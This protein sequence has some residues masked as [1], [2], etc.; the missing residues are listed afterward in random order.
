MEEKWIGNGR[1]ELNSNKC[2]VVN[3]RSLSH[4]FGW[5]FGRYR[6]QAHFMTC[7]FAFFAF[8]DIVN[9]KVYILRVMTDQKREALN[10]LYKQLDDNKINYSH[11]FLRCVAQSQ[12]VLQVVLQSS[13]E[14]TLNQML[15]GARNA[16][17]NALQSN[18]VRNNN[19]RAVMQWSIAHINTM[20]WTA[21]VPF[22]G[23]ITALYTAIWQPT[24]ERARFCNEAG[25]NQKFH[26]YWIVNWAQFTALQN[27]PVLVERFLRL[28]EAT[29]CSPA[30]IASFREI[31]LP[32]T[33]INQANSPQTRLAVIAAMRQDP[34]FE[35]TITN[36][37]FRNT[38]QRALLLSYLDWLR[39][40]VTN[41]EHSRYREWLYDL[42]YL[43]FLQRTGRMQ[44]QNW[45]LNKADFF[46]S[47][48][49]QR[50]IDEI[51]RPD[52][53]RFTR[54]TNLRNRNAGVYQ[55]GGRLTGNG[56]E[57]GI[58]FSPTPDSIEVKQNPRASFDVNTNANNTLK[59]IDVRDDTNTS[60]WTFRS[61]EKVPL[62][63]LSRADRVV[64]TVWVQPQVSMKSLLNNATVAFE[65]PEEDVT[66]EMNRD[67]LNNLLASVVPANA[68]IF[69]PQPRDNVP[70]NQVIESVP[71]D[72][73]WINSDTIARCTT[74]EMSIDGWRSRVPAWSDLTI[75]AWWVQMIVRTRSSNTANTP[76]VCEVEIWWVR[77]G[78]SVTTEALT[79]EYPV[80]APQQ[81]TNVAV[82][83]VIESDPF[84]ITG[85]TRP[86]TAICTWGEMSID[87]WLS[88]T[89]AWTNL[90]VPVWVQMLLR[91]TSSAA[92]NTRS[93]C[94]VDIWWVTKSFFVTTENTPSVSPI[95]FSEPVWSR[96]DGNI[97]TKAV[98]RWTWP[99]SLSGWT[100]EVINA[101]GTVVLTESNLQ[102]NTTG[103]WNREID[104]LWLP[105]GTYMVRVAL[106]TQTQDKS[107]HYTVPTPVTPTLEKPTDFTFWDKIDQPCGQSIDSDSV[108]IWWLTWPVPVVINPPWSLIVINGVEY[109]TAWAI[110]DV[111][112]G[113]NV[114]LRVQSSPNH[115]TYT[116]M[117]VLIGSLPK[118]FRVRTI[119]APPTIERP[120]INKPWSFVYWWAPVDIEWV[121]EKGHLVV[122]RD[123][124]TIL[125][126]VRCSATW[127]WKLPVGNLTEWTHTLTV[128]GCD[129]SWAEVAWLD[130]TLDIIVGYMRMEWL[131]WTR[132]DI[133][134]RMH[135][136]PN[137]RYTARR[138]K[139]DD[140][141]RNTIHGLL[142]AAWQDNITFAGLALGHGKYEVECYQSDENEAKK[143]LFTIDPEPVTITPLVPN[144]RR[145]RL[146]WTA[147]A[148][149]EVIIKMKIWGGQEK[150]YK[151]QASDTWNRSVQLDDLTSGLCTIDVTC[152]WNTLHEELDLDIPN[153]R[154]I[155]NNSN[156]IVKEW[157]ETF[158]VSGY[159]PRE[160]LDCDRVIIADKDWNT[161][162][163]LDLWNRTRWGAFRDAGR[164]I[165][166][167]WRTR[168]R[169]NSFETDLNVN[170][171]WLELWKNT[172]IQIIPV[173]RDGTE[174]TQESLTT[175][176]EYR[177]DIHQKHVTALEPAGVIKEANVK[178]AWKAPKGVKRVRV[179]KE[180]IG[181][182]HGRLRW[183]SE[184]EFV[185]VD[186]NGN[187][188]TTKTITKDGEQHWRVAAVDDDW[189][190]G[191][192]S[193][194][195]FV[196]K[197]PENEGKLPWW[198]KALPWNWFGKGKKWA[199]KEWEEKEGGKWGKES[200]SEWGKEWGENGSWSKKTW[201]FWGLFGG[202]RNKESMWSRISRG[203]NGDTRIH[204]HLNDNYDPLKSWK[205]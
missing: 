39:D 21:T 16:L 31:L 9:G 196:M 135:G 89:P 51:I 60:I 133:T 144:Q 22:D 53:N 18:V 55:N 129:A 11:N 28:C 130:S 168:R 83:T 13:D 112:N 155:L 190:I 98:F 132:N 58:E 140:T 114:V 29:W 174:Y 137:K 15:A 177:H 204:K 113:D 62:A 78:F 126:T 100:I 37:T 105:S 19:H 200:W 166:E 33:R 71:F 184:K 194:I 151:V 118:T 180:G 157:Q 79:P 124:A 201:W 149:E 52:F 95:V 161:I 176:V 93:A 205:K 154:P 92:Y 77:R 26:A 165:L 107:I 63:V 122:V 131:T 115:A 101:T 169:D 41:A 203:L 44:N 49:C 187:W 85:I 36:R 136:E 191:P 90:P 117:S 192:S 143:W 27:N 159:L 10:I 2:S 121:G 54:I 147:E 103:I 80:F 38:A 68:P 102:T 91:T 198:K 61:G 3:M 48:E 45:H 189:T 153:R 109:P 59:T 97:S 64:W 14:N 46:T 67:Q 156:I 23:E 197:L 75:P 111:V 12:E 66:V 127:E 110:P 167:L 72:V 65:A 160:C 186:D 185:S 87:G 43:P 25:I 70:M 188:E 99:N 40:D 50:Y 142:P 158:D 69:A 119:D 178:F 152:A 47:D 88:W 108:T 106:G 32:N 86:T 104:F 116:Q 8:L 20:L 183:K 179:R 56:D 81:K 175:T 195:D 150:E 173:G 7:K 193:P 57:T 164:N 1:S 5:K 6:R 123:W 30:V 125:G 146:T 4:F 34:V 42:Y 162:K 73:T 145:Q 84:D 171:L 182:M 199:W 181:L 202:E 82:S 24:N 74:W 96:I 120:T 76:T 17:Q 163:T 139:A 35:E 172:S 148:G 128:T 138:K 134:F 141:N 94:T 170:D